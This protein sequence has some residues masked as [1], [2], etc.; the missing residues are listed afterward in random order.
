MHGRINDVNAIG[1]VHA[2]KHR[3]ERVVVALADR[4]ELVVVT[5][6]ALDGG[7]GEGLHHRGDHVV[8][9]EVAADLAVNCILTD[10]TQRTLVPWPRSDKSE[11]DRGLR[12]AR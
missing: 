8:A 9:V 5:S 4:I 2:G 11:R 3:L 1:P 12:I 6:R 10:V 7:A